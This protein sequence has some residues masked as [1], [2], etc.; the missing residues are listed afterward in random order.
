MIVVP[1]SGGTKL[2]QNEGEDR[3]KIADSYACKQGDSKLN[4]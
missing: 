1:S 2:L 3:G 4:I